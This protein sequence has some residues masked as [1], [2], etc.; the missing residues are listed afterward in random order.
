MKINDNSDNDPIGLGALVSGVG[1]CECSAG[2]C[3]H[4]TGWEHWLLEGREGSL[5]RVRDS[6]KDT[7][8]CS[9]SPIL[10]P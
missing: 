5:P 2:H 3:E 9:C 7:P 10:S 1:H 6:G 4:G 8:V